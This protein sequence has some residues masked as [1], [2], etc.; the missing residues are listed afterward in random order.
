MSKPESEPGSDTIDIG[1]D[2][3]TTNSAIAIAA[4][5]DATIVKNNNSNDI[6]PSAVWIPRNDLIYVGYQARKRAEKDPDNTATE[7]K[8]MMGYDGTEWSFAAAGITMTPQQLSAE[9]LKT[10]RYDVARLLGSAPDVAVI[11]VPA[12]FALNQR[13]ATLQAAELAGLGRD[14]PLIPEPTAAAFAYASHEGRGRGYWLVF[15]F[16]GGTFDAAVVDR[17]DEEL[18][19]LTHAGDRTLGGRLIDWAIV[20]H[21]L[22]PAVARQFGFRDFSRDNRRFTG[23]FGSLK[24]SAEQAKIDLSHYDS[25]ELLTEINVDGRLGGSE[26]MFAVTLRRDALDAL[27]EPFYTRAINL[28]RTAIADAALHVRQID[29]VVLVGG[30]TLAPGLRERL[31]DGRRGLGI[32]VD[33]SAD[34]TT[35]VARGAALFAATVRRPPRFAPTPRAGAFVLELTH[36]PTVTT[37]TAVVAGRI[38][39]TPTDGWTGYSVTLDN[40]ESAVPFRSGRIPLNDKGAFGTMVDLDADRTSRFRVELTDGTGTPCELEPDTVVLTHRAG[41]ELGGVTLGDSL[42]V[43]RADEGFTVLLRKGTTLPATVHKPFKTS[44]ALRRADLDGVLR[45]PIAEGDRSRGE[46]NRRVGMLE[47]RSADM[48]IDLPAGSEVEVTFEV[49][50]SGMVTA[51]ADLPVADVQAEVVIDL[52]SVAP[53]THEKLVEQFRELEERLKMLPG[54]SDMSSP[55]APLWRRIDEEKA[56][57]SLREQVDAAAVDP[58]AAVAAEDRI[59]D[60]HS[61]LDD[62]ADALAVPELIRELE[63]TLADTLVLIDRIGDAGDRRSHAELR[64]RADEAIRTRDAVAIRRQLDRAHEFMIDLLQ[65]HPDFPLLV[66]HSLAERLQDTP[67]AGPLLREGSRAAASGDMREL[68]SIN[69]RLRMLLP[70]DMPTG[71]IGVVE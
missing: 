11:T 52:N 20:E 38:H 42:G 35:V 66:F 40:S 26:E 18:R 16:G 39:G 12:A 30:T 29:R 63:T 23:V 64:A 51:V 34:P 45:I 33:F 60:L 13:N 48:H 2:L 47:I 44:D 17:S 9:I 56:I 10:L 46:R 58:I 59:R 32:E 14:C 19:V 3:G 41:P 15:D 43:S 69:H 54:R 21:V 8:Q 37:T 61:D 4:D 36:E 28:A 7:F 70:P 53:S 27:A 1:I 6:T 31:A 67:A 5:G 55:A 57:S 68:T 65:H 24:T 22:A 49:N 71:P 25:A 50:Q 62:V